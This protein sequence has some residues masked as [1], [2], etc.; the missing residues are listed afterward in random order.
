MQR[1]KTWFLHLS[2]LAIYGVV[3][4]FS[5]ALGPAIVR[6]QTSCP[7]VKV[8]CRDGTYK[9]CNGTLQGGYCYYDRSCMNGGT[10]GS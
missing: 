8:P 10:C 1:F 4:L 7:P 2:V 5:A 6:A 3:G 9:T